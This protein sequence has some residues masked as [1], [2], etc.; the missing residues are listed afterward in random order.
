MN[1][2]LKEKIIQKCF[3]ISGWAN[4]RGK[5]SLKG[6]NT[7]AKKAGDILDKLIKDLVRFIKDEIRD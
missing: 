4:I 7:G 2:E 3:G 5:F 6:D 1:Q